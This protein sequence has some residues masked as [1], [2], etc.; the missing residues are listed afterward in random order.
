MYNKSKKW[1][2]PTRGPLFITAIIANILAAVFTIGLVLIYL[3]GYIT[4]EGA[5]GMFIILLFPFALAI[6]PAGVLNIIIAIRLSK[7][8][9]S[10]AGFYYL[11]AVWILMSLYFLLNYVI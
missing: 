1:T 2:S 8:K 5:F 11:S 6:P 3:V 7:A 10:S 4:G 9:R